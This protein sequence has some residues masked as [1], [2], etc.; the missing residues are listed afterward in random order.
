MRAAG[1][2]IASDSTPRFV[3]LFSPRAPASPAGAWRTI[4]SFWL[5]K[6][7]TRLEALNPCEAVC[8]RSTPRTTGASMPIS[9]EIEDGLIPLSFESTSTTEL[10]L[11]PKRLLTI[12]WPNFSSSSVWPP[13]IPLMLERM[14]LAFAP[15]SPPTMFARR[16]APEGVDAVCRKPARSVGIPASTAFCVLAPLSPSSPLILPMA[17]SGIH[18]LTRSIRFVVIVYHLSESLSGM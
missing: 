6:R 5:V 14:S 1:C 3:R 2:R 9:D 17:S 13:S 16:L 10:G 8:C 15:S 4:A 18:F 12:I 7:L 11:L